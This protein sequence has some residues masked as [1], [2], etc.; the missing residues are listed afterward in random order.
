MSW[1]IV[2]GKKSKPITVQSLALNEL[3]VQDA[4]GLRNPLVRLAAHGR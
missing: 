3:S 2:Y 4:S 1:D